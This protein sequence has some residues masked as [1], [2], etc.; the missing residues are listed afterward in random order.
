MNDGGRFD[1]HVHS[2]YSPD[3]KLSLEE[4]VAR[5]SYVGLRGFA[6]TDHNSV[7]GHAGLADLQARYP[8]YLFVPGVEISTREGHLLALGVHEPPP[9]GRPIAETV[10]WVRAHGGESVPSHPF[11]RT[12][13]IG[14]RVVESVDVT[15]LETRNGHSSEIDNLRAA[16]VAARRGLG[17]TG[18]SDAHSLRDIGRTYTEFEDPVAT[19]DDLLEAI[20]RK[21]T[22]ADGKSMPLGG[23]LR[24]SLRS[25][26]LR[27]GRGFRPV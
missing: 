26:L 18:G 8:A 14:R 4:I 9:P 25:A 10:D 5:L 19:V 27:A 16:D 3:S 23:R 1:L 17:E 20:R 7:R 22:G 13:G 11:R 2:V 15:A 12:H 6:L 24:L 21:R